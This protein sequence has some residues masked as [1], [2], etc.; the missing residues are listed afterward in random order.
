[1]STNKSHTIAQMKDKIGAVREG[2]KELFP[3][4]SNQLSN[5]SICIVLDHFNYDVISV[6]D[7]F[8]DGEADNLLTEWKKAGKQTKSKKKKKN[9]KKKQAN[10]NVESAASQNA[11]TNRSDL[12][13]EISG[14][15]INDKSNGLP[16]NETET[17]QNL[18]GKVPEGD[19]IKT[20]QL[21]TQNKTEKMS[22]NKK[23]LKVS[24]SNNLNENKS[25]SAFKEKN[26]MKHATSGN[27]KNH[28]PV[29]ND[30]AT[31]VANKKH[32][33]KACKDIQRYLLSLDRYSS[34]MNEDFEASYKDL[35]QAFQSFGDALID[36]EVQLIRKIDIKKD[37]RRA[38]L[39][40]RKSEA[41]ILKT[42]T[43]RVGQMTSSEV[44]NLRSEIKQFVSERKHDEDSLK[45][46][47][48]KF[49]AE[50]LLEKI[51]EFGEDADKK[52]IVEDT[53]NDQVSSEP[54]DVEISKE[55]VYKTEDLKKIDKDDKD[56]E[57]I[58]KLTD[59]I[60]LSANDQIT[61]WS[62]PVSSH[63][64]QASWATEEASTNYLKNSSSNHQNTRTNQYSRGQNNRRQNNRWNQRSNYQFDGYHGNQDSR[65][66]TSS[67]GQV[68]RRS[69]PNGP[70]QPDSRSNGPASG[71][72][73]DY[74]Q[75]RTGYRNRG[76]R[77][78]RYQG[79]SNFRGNNYRNRGN[80][81]RNGPRR[82]END[83][84]P[85]FGHQ[86][87]ISAEQTA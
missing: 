55:A 10:G 60:N 17:K 12:S 36:R 75:Q 24:S 61:D 65:P 35:K 39:Q 42:R 77:N 73:P 59:E 56:E 7:A 80:N 85:T 22:Q 41:T 19:S 69:R 44:N 31:V 34:I 28:Q 87:P 3:D 21:K 67:K 13:S 4:K 62:D 45:N 84:K 81:F 30:N 47:R 79:N 83:Q 53:S 43:D 14:E 70:Q 58:I 68:Y 71:D 2:I 78:P 46:C 16:P 11:K 18:N 50:I 38:F 20:S 64:E 9:T 86:Q 63:F 40:R 52:K 74:R 29:D 37:E 23:S 57:D 51:Q 48:F 5:D 6:I 49:D 15:K 27:Q 8:L 76:N 1:M 25:K 66:P 32:I 72:G 33:E 26:N 82:Y 54:A